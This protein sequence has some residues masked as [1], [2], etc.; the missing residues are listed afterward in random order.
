RSR[1]WMRSVQSRWTRAVVQACPPHLLA[2]APGM[3][4]QPGSAL[5]PPALSDARDATSA[6]A[7]A[8]LAMV[9]EAR[10]ARADRAALAKRVAAADERREAAATG[11]KPTVGVSGG[12]DYA[13][14][15]PRIFPRQAA[16]RES[17]DASVSLNWPLFD[18]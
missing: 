17:W 1:Q 14:P 3:L 7:R 10:V 4:M 9:D 8:V 2:T 6:S 5:E 12:F 11:N 16:W 15:N 13:R 18:G